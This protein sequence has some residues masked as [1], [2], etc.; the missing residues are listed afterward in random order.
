MPHTTTTVHQ[1]RTDLVPIPVRRPIAS[2]SGPLT[3]A[4]LRMALRLTGSIARSTAARTL[5][6][7]LAIL[8]IGSVHSPSAMASGGIGTAAY[9]AGDCHRLGPRTLCVTR[10]QRHHIRMDWG[11][12]VITSDIR[13]GCPWAKPRIV[14][15]HVYPRQYLWTVHYCGNDHDFGM[16]RA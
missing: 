10:Y 8:A 1:P 14:A 2:S 13:V 12:S 15:T 6:A 5:L 11:R 9:A 4:D 3:A 16:A 7:V